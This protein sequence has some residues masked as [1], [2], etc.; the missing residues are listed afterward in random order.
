MDLADF[1]GVYSATFTPYD[2]QGR[3]CSEMQ[4]RLIDFHARNGLRGLYLCGS[5]GEGVL[6]DTEE[7]KQ[8]TRSAVAAAQGRLRIITHVGHAATDVAVEL[9]RDAEAVGA[10]AVSSV[11]P[12]YY[13]YT[14]EIEYRHYRAIADAVDIPLFIYAHPILTGREMPADHLLRLFE[15]PNIVGVKYTGMD[16]YSMRNIS[17]RVPKPH[18]ILGGSDERMIQGLVS[19]TRGAIG[20]YQNVVPAAF[21]TLHDLFRQGRVD[22]AMGMQQRVNALVTA[23]QAKRD[24]S[25]PKAIMRHIG[26]DCGWCR[27]P[28]KQL[29]ERE[30]AEFA[31]ELEAFDEL[32]ALSELP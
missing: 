7:R 27:R 8:V 9:A 32:F 14:D 2:R 24:L 13:S 30:Y 23:V 22:E 10:D 31:R 20:S 4:A 25:Y 28:F 26:F 17:D 11:H 3:F 5:T 6:L 21:V 18:L 15:I 12:I 1:E 19:G 29:T 16:F